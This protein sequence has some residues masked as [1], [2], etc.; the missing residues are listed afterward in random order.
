[1]VC[2]RELAIEAFVPREYWTI[3][4]QLANTADSKFTARLHRRDGENLDKFAIENQQQAEGILAELEQAEF[5]IS[6]L[7]KKTA[8]A[9]SGTAVHHQYPA[10]GSQPQNRFLGAQDHDRS[11]ETI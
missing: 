10:A 9:Q 7:E 2:E 8:Q 6:K 5:R 1:M 4:A 3:E 11:A